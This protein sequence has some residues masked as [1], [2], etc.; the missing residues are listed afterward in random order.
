[1]IGKD[2]IST[3]ILI[4]AVSY[5]TLLDIIVGRMHIVFNSKN[6]IKFYTVLHLSIACNTKIFKRVKLSSLITDTHKIYICL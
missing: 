2:I 6:T 1:M 5:G 3:D 4:F